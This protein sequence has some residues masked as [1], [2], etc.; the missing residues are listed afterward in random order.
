MWVIPSPCGT[1]WDSITPTAAALIAPRYPC[2]PWTNAPPTSPATSWFAAT[3]A[4]PIK[5]A[6]VAATAA[7]TGATAGDPGN[8][9]PAGAPVAQIASGIPF[10]VYCASTPAWTCAFTP[11]VTAW[12][13]AA[14][15]TGS[16]AKSPATWAPRSAGIPS[17]PFNLNVGPMAVNCVEPDLAKV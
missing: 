1:L 12:V 10:A 11:A 8:S 7:D 2:P 3:I 6:A 15:I 5:G 14:L 4:G 9:A 17:A 16:E 13:I